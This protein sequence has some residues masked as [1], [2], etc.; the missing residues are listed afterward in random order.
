MNSAVFYDLNTPIIGFVVLLISLP[1]PIG[2]KGLLIKCYRFIH[3]IRKI[4][5]CNVRLKI[6]ILIL[7]EKALHKRRPA[8]LVLL[9]PL[10]H[11]AYIN[12]TV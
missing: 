7:P 2:M 1:T 4:Q 5:F 11:K 6:Q 8:S 12:M 10:V 9:W 3:T